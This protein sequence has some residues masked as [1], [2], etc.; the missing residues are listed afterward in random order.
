MTNA[1]ERETGRTSFS[2]DMKMQMALALLYVG[3]EIMCC[4]MALLSIEITS[5]SRLE[6]AD[7]I[8]ARS[9]RLASWSGVGATFAVAARV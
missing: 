6:R 3:W 9:W 4:V 7:L 8:W 1:A 5:E 2:I